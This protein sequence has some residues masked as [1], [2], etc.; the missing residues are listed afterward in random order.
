MPPPS[1]TGDPIFVVIMMMAFLKL[2][3]LPVESV[4]MPSSEEF[5]EV[6]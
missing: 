5:A 4:R 1:A 6:D 3:V 2:A